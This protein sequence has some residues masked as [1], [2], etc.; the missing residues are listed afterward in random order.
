MTF[1]FVVVENF[2]LPLIGLKGKVDG[3][4]A[5]KA[6]SG[7]EEE[8]LDDWLTISVPTSAGNSEMTDYFLC[9]PSPTTDK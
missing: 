1:V 6:R 4:W 5:W 2:C 3:G 8:V 9:G 7:Q